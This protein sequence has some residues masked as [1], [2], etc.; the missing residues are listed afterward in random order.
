MIST[1]KTRHNLKTALKIRRKYINIAMIGFLCMLV[2]LIFA[3]SDKH[4]LNDFFPEWA[5]RF[6]ITHIRK[7]TLL[8]V[9]L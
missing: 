7:Y 4:V 1:M 5:C 6:I 3:D 9:N 2:P 8:K